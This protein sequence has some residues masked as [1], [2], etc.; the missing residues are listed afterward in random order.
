M[1]MLPEPELYRERAWACLT[2]FSGSFSFFGL[3]GSFGSNNEVN[4]TN[5][6]DQTDQPAPRLRHRYA[7]WETI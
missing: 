5:K 7:Q 3:F 2:G 6:I 1:R 4:Q